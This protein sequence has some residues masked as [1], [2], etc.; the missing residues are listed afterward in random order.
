M[1]GAAAVLAAFALAGSAAAV[2]P[3]RA[4]PFD[5]Y[6]LAGQ[7]NMS[8]RGALAALTPAERVADPRI[9]LYGNDARWRDALDPLDDA[10]DQIDA[11]SADRQAAVGPGLPFARRMLRGRGRP[12]ALVPCAKGGSAIAAWHA[13]AAPDTLYGSCLRRTREARG[14]LAGL[15]WYQGESDA[16]APTA[17][18]WSDRFA[19]LVAALRQDLAAPR[20]PVVFVRIADRPTINA[21]RYPYWTMVQDRQA[22]VALPCVAMVSAGGLTRN[23]DDL[24]LDTGAQRRLGARIAE[25]MI[26]LQRRGCGR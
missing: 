24:H 11:V 18:L 5:V 22:S 26:R 9:R 16:Q 25:A 4:A 23:P 8:G 17:D 15:L 21:D 1:K 3:E 2:R 7:S 12:V 6:V 10:A 14:R 20:L 19:A 13:D